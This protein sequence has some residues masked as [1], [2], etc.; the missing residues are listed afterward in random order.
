[1]NSLDY[2]YFFTKDEVSGDYHPATGFNTFQLREYHKGEYIA[3]KGEVVSSLSIVVE[4]SITVEFVIDSGLVI[5][6]VRHAAPILIGAMALLTNESRYLADTIAN[7]DVKIITYS[8]EQIERRMQSD[9]K[10]MYNLISFISSRVE[11]LSSHIAILAQRNIKAKVAYYI[12]ISSNGVHYRFTRSIASLAEYLCV[13]RPSLSRTISQ[14][15]AEGLISYK[16]G[17]G[18]ILDPSA[19]KALLE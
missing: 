10:F 18:K 2:S 8:R 5:R 19:M 3:T 17:E 14:M 6:S 1:M 7:E 4:G 12:F 11:N 16:N 13:T 15:V 9:I